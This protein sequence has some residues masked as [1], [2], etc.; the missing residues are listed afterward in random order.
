MSENDPD[1]EF[2]KDNSVM[3]ELCLPAC[4]YTSYDLSNDY[5][6]LIDTGSGLL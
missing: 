3:C 4:T 5:A 6:T 1:L 2:E